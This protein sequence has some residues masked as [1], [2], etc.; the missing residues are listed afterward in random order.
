MGGERTM[1]MAELIITVRHTVSGSRD[2][3]E[4]VLERLRGGSWPV[5]EDHV[6]LTSQKVRE[7]YYQSMVRRSEVVEDVPTTGLAVRIIWES[8]YPQVFPENRNF[9][10][11]SIKGLYETFYEGMGQNKA[12]D[13]I[14]E[15][16]QIHAFRTI[17]VVKVELLEDS[18]V[19][20]SSG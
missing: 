7:T 19:I 15:K 20:H 13:Y 9:D 8:G 2:Q 6:Y 16:H 10:A 17:G 12:A 5:E 14:D 3:L 11:G 4:Q 1:G 18:A